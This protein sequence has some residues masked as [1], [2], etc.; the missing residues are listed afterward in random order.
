MLWKLL[1]SQCL[2]NKNTSHHAKVDSDE[3]QSRKQKEGKRGFTVSPVEIVL[4]VAFVLFIAS[5]I[6][7]RIF[8]VN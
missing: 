8:F 2:I 4:S 3:F 7:W 6:I 5:I 1:I